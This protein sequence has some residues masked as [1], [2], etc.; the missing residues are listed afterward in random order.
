M[1][2]VQARIFDQILLRMVM[3][4]PNLPHTPR[5][6]FPQ[7]VIFSLQLLFLCGNCAKF[8]PEQIGPAEKY[9]KEQQ[10]F[11]PKQKN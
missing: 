1:R 4:Y 2:N 7:Y 8:V 9:I 6:K 10:L 5:Y 3:L 11:I